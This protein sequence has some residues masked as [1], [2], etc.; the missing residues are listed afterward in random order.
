M[1]IL[2][3]GCVHGM[4]DIVCELI[5]RHSPDVCIITGDLQT[6]TNEAE[7]KASGM[8]AKY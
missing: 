5:S 4:W 3:L 6:F 7:M 8:K 1:R 2:A